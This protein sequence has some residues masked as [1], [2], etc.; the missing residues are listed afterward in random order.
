MARKVDSMQEQMAEEHD[1]NSETPKG[2]G[3]KKTL[4]NKGSIIDQAMCTS[5]CLSEALPN[6]EQRV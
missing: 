5:H 6:S 2:G 3:I 4:T 1:G